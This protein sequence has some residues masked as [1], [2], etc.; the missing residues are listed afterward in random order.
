MRNGPGWRQL[1]TTLLILSSIMPARAAGQTDRT[2]MVDGLAMHVVSVGLESRNPEQPVVIFE[3][4]QGSPL[5]TWTPI[6]PAVAEFAPVLTYDRSGVGTTPW[7]GQPRTPARVVARL[8]AL[9][10]EL[11]VAPPYVLVGHS[12]GGP[13]IHHFAGEYPDQVVGMVYID[14]TDF[15]WSSDVERAILESLAPG[16]AWVEWYDRREQQ[17]EETRA[18]RPAVIRAVT[19]ATNEYLDRD[20]GED[21][22][23]PDVPTSVI[24]ASRVIRRS[25]RVRR[26]N[27][28]LPYDQS[29]F[30]DVRH[31]TIMAHLHSW[32]RPGG[33]FVMA[34]TPRH[35]V[36][37]AEPEMVVDVIRRVL[38]ASRD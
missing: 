30:I 25:N 9:L 26:S 1:G 15:M 31:D 23:A 10:D 36:H 20:R 28:D 27:P 3:S 16:G 11:D 8:H 2:V 37:A 13:L 33:E 29:A 32:V 34:T 12:W 17:R 5:R 24:K 35:A 14:P 7:D 21:R 4:G 6:L 22:P 38:L 18:S 19:S